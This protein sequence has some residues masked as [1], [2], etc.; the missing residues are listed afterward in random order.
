MSNIVTIDVKE[1]LKREKEQE[2]RD[3]ELKKEQEKQRKEQ[4]QRDKEL[5]REQEKKEKELKKELEKQR[6]EEEKKEKEFQK[7]LKREQEKIEKREREEKKEQEKREREEEKDRKK[8][9]RLEEKQRLDEERKKKE[10][11]LK[12]KTEVSKIEALISTTNVDRFT[13][14]DNLVIKETEYYDARCIAYVWLNWDRLVEEKKIGRAF[15][16]ISCEYVPDLVYKSQFE[17]FIKELD[18][19][20]FPIAKRKLTYTQSSYNYG[21][22]ICRDI[23]GL[24]GISRPLRHTFCEDIYRDL[25]VVNC[26]PLIYLNLC[27]QHNLPTTYLEIY[28]NHREQLIAELV[29]ENPTTNR[30]F[31][32]TLFLSRLNGG[33][34]PSCK[35]MKDI[36]ESE[37]TIEFYKEVQSNHEVL[38]KIFDEIHPEYRKSVEKAYGNDH[39]NLN[40]SIV[41]HYLCDKENQILFYLRDY[42]K[43][44][45]T[46]KLESGE[47]VHYPLSPEVLCFDGCMINIRNKKDLE[48][49]NDELIKRA[50]NYIELKTGLSISLK[51]KDFDEMI[52]IP[53][54]ELCK[55]T[56]DLSFWKYFNWKKIDELGGS[57]KVCADLCSKYFKDD[58]I[59]T[60][61]ITN[62]GFS[63]QEDTRL[64]K[65]ITQ[66]D[67]QNS[68]SDLLQDAVRKG[69]KHW[70]SQLNVEEEED[71][72]EAL[73]TKCMEW[74]NRIKDVNNWGNNRKAREVFT[75]LKPMLKCDDFEGKM[76][77]NQIYELPIKNGLVI[78]LRYGTTRERKSTDYYN[79]ECKVNYTPWSSYNEE[80]RQPVIEY[81]NT[82]FHSNQK[83]IDYMQVLTGML[84][85]KDVSCRSFYMVPGSGRNGKSFYFNDLLKAILNKSY[86]T[87]DNKTFVGKAN[88]ID[89]LRSITDASISV[90]SE[91]EEGA[92]LNVSLL[93][94]I[95]GN[96]DFKGE[97]KGKSMIDFKAYCKPILLFND[98]QAPECDAKD[99]ALWDRLVCLWFPHQFDITKKKENKSKTDYYLRNIDVFFSYFFEGCKIWYENPDLLNDKPKEIEEETY[100]FRNKNDDIVNFIE[101]TCEID[102]KFTI[103]K[104]HLYNAFCRYG[105]NKNLWTKPMGRNTFYTQMFKKNYTE[106]RVNDIHCFKGLRLKQ[107][108]NDRNTN[109]CTHS[110]RDG[111]KPDEYDWKCLDC[112]YIQPLNLNDF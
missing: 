110:I 111:T 84:L 30:S 47:S 61:V 55:M 97:V 53:E 38:V 1:Q 96:D 59:L 19:E 36:I 5:K 101:E 73:K 21:R 76:N 102:T 56:A 68:I 42:L 43:Y 70:L 92:K 107:I 16:P 49:C 72:R 46:V 85:T 22:Y 54:S 13:H 18:I 45:H 98:A 93:K 48:Q 37:E 12:Y 77:I 28:I 80:Q 15:D 100:R 105:D 33:S 104:E 69:I 83:V 62:D 41:N 103:E 87:V 8:I 86:A 11:D 34:S 74:V 109:N 90:F 20:E 27:K 75:C 6:K 67:I 60:N 32:K 3:K 31:W 81:M 25:D 64:W 88:Y 112:G 108:N 35:L 78:D 63:F 58:F 52:D 44:E 51:F 65:T 2:K 89:N 9:E 4:A 71:K 99:E 95:T 66:Y 82:M 91:G 23:L 94:R 10:K 17:K 14:W 79:Y 7:E 50:Q 57:D 29:K 26:H 24:Q 40:G 106:V 39:W